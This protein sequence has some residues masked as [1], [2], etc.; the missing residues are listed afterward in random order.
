MLV[1]YQYRYW[2]FIHIT[3]AMCLFPFLQQRKPTDQ[4]QVLMFCFAAFD[5]CLIMVRVPKES[6]KPFSE[7]IYSDA[8]FFSV[9]QKQTEFLCSRH[10][11]YLKTFHKA[12]QT[13][14]TGGVKSDHKGHMVTNAKMQDLHKNQDV[15]RI[16]YSHYGTYFQK[17]A[18][19]F[20]LFF[21]K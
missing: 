14:L 19:A 4:D 7:A 5:N 9:C 18:R 3:E 17:I 2:I 12:R 6:F 1:C 21:H 11:K 8:A 16:T 13:F 20:C 15:I 10:I